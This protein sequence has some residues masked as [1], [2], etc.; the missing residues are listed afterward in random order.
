MILTTGSATP[1]SSQGRGIDTRFGR[2]PGG[3]VSPGALRGPEA[4]SAIGARSQSGR[5]FLEK[6][7]EDLDGMS[8]DDLIMNALRA[9]SGLT[10]LSRPPS[11]ATGRVP[12]WTETKSNSRIIRA[13]IVLLV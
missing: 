11:L 5:T 1:T 7:Y 2:A 4:A 3:A 13:T 6:I 10:H 12:L 9:L 8:K